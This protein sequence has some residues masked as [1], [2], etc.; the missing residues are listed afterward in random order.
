MGLLA[1]L[2]GFVLGDSLGGS[3]P[4]TNDSSNVTATEV[5]NALN[6]ASKLKECAY[7]G[8]PLGDDSFAEMVYGFWI[9]GC[10]PCL[11]RLGTLNNKLKNLLVRHS[12]K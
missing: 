4:N 3:P 5:S 2:I 8:K 10:M 9:P 12:N 1:F 6:K 11:E 7:C